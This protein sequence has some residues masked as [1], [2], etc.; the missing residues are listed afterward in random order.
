[1]RHLYRRCTIA[2][3]IGVTLAGLQLFAQQLGTAGIY[4]AVTDPQGAVIPGATVTLIHVERNQER[5][6]TANNGGQYVFPLIPVG[7][8]RIRVKH[9]GFKTFEQTGIVLEVNDN[10][11]IDVALEVGDIATET[12]VEAAPAAVEASTATLKSVVDGRRILEIPLN[13]RNVAD[14]TGLVPGVQD[15]GASGGSAK[16]P[17]GV[18]Q[19]SVNGSRQNNLKFTLDGGDNQDNLTNVNMPFPFPDAVEEFSVQTRTPGPRS[20]R[21]RPE[22]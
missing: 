17:S 7:T 18:H 11:K 5:L 22:P 21:A 10:R 19:F 20:A 4:G 8:Y 16:T 14:L 6:T 2:V 9:P 13:G 12:V 15:A 3:L 1:M